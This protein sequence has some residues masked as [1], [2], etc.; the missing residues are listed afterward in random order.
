MPRIINNIRKIEIRRDL[1][2]NQTKE[3]ILLWSKLKNNQTGYKWRRQVSKG[4]YVADFYCRKKLVVVELDGSQH[5]DN[6]EYDKD[7]DTF[8]RFLRIKTLRFWN[9]E[10][11][12]NITFVIKKISYEL[13]KTSPQPSPGKERAK[14]LDIV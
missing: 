10:I 9:D 5:L 8:F 7:R 6:K 11:R 14:F 3:E 12:I 2:K 13:N 4:D 1:R